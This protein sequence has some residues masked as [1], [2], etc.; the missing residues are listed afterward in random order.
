MKKIILFLLY[1]TFACGQ[2]HIV[3]TTQGLVQGYTNNKIAIYKGIP[4]AQPPV[5]DLRWKVPMPA[6][7]WKGIKSCT[8]Y[9]AS[10]M[11]TPPSPFMFWST[12]FLIPKEPIGEDCLYLN[13]W[14]GATVPKDKKPVIVYIYGG[15]FRSG[16]T[17]CQIYDGES[18]A[19]KGIIFVSINYR[20]GVFGFFAHPE[21][22]KE[23]KEHASGNYAL[24]DMIAALKWVKQNIKAFGGDPGNV[25]IAGQSA[26]AF[27]VNYLQASPLAKGLFHKAIAQ[28][29]GSF[30]THPSRPQ[31]ALQDAETIGVKFAEDLHCTNLA[32]LRLKSADEILKAR[33]DFSF[34][35]LDGRIIP[36]PIMSIFQKGKQNDVPIMVGWN[37]DDRVSGPP[38]KAATF[39]EQAIKR[40]ADLSSA[41]LMAYPAETDEQAAQS[42]IANGRDET[43]G[44][45]NYTWAKMQTKT[46]SAKAYVYNFN[47][48]LPAYNM[49]TQFGAF[50]SGEIVYAYDNLHTLDRPWE[51]AD[52]LIADRMSSYWANFAK[53]GNPNGKG[54]PIW[55]A[56][57]PSHEQ[58]LI[59]D[60]ECIAK[61]L[62]TKKQ[63]EFWEGYFNRQ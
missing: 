11:Q 45:Q 15:G 36:E 3:K 33:Y 32:T 7:P 25:T 59:I 54:L 20:V 4:F 9:S 31:L 8:T 1:T 29:G 5:G 23:V 2:T 12:E 46:G 48:K 49:E 56:Y 62:P 58:V 61:P 35:I 34:P 24:M 43:F 38:L 14:T 10:P 17:A 6:R 44:I 30:Y 19:K 27:A 41:Y 51:D 39:K 26:G 52:H 13:I 63:M 50:H 18:M 40:F 53:T 21:L 22:S 28:S 47:R 16:G 57:D 55:P 37:E 60:K 42:Q